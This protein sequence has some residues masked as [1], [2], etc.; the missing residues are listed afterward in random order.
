MYFDENGEF[1]F[2]DMYEFEVD[3]ETEDILFKHG[4]EMLSWND[5]ID[6]LS[7]NK[8]TYKRYVKMTKLKPGEARCVV[9]SHIM[10]AEIKKKAMKS[11]RNLTCSICGAKLHWDSLRQSFLLVGFDTNG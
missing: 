7:S 1:H 9:C 5:Y 10:P 11:R 6:R 4:D 8:K 2:D 3:D